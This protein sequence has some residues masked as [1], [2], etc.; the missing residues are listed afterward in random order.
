M[1]EQEWLTCEEPARMLELMRDT[2]SD[3]KWRLVVCRLALL[4]H[5]IRQ[6]DY[7]NAVK[8]VELGELW[9]DG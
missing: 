1:T 3:R 7:L 9:A 2:A 8:S 4:D 6:A 5:T